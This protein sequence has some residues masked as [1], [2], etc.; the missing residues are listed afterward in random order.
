MIGYNQVARVN[1]IETAKIQADM[2]A[3]NLINGQQIIPAENLFKMKITCPLKKWRVCI[4]LGWMFPFRPGNISFKLMC[5]ITCAAVFFSCNSRQPAGL[6]IYNAKIYTVDSVFTIDEAMAV[7]NGKIVAVGKND[8]LLKRYKADSMINAKGMPVFPGF[9]DAH[10]HFL[11]YGRGLFDVDLFDC[12]DWDEAVER[13]KTFAR[14]HPS[15]SWI[16][17]RGWDQ[18]KW[19]GK[20]FPDNAKLNELFP[21]KPMLL[22]RVDGHAAVANAKALQLAGIIPGQ[23]IEGGEIE[24]KDGRLTGLLID[25][26]VELVKRVIPP[27]SKSD[28]EKWLMAAQRNCFAQGLTTITDCGLMYSDIAIIDSLQREGK[29]LMR[30]YVMLS[31]DTANFNRFLQRGPYK[32]E[33][34]YV[35]GV[36]AY[37]DG[38]LGSRGA[39]LLQPY[40]DKPGWH[41]FLLSS[42]RHFDSLAKMLLHTDFQLCTHAIGDSGNRIMLKIYNKYLQGQ[43]DKRWRIEHAQVIDTNDFALFG[44]TS[45]IPSVQPTHAT[46]DMYW[47]GDRLGPERLKGA[48]AYRQLL[49]QN[50]WIPLGTD[51]PVEDISPIKTFYAAVFRKDARGF[52]PNGFQMENALTREQALR[53]M[54][55]W[56]ARADFL[57]KEVGSIEV[58]KNADFVILDKDLMVV[59]ENQVLTTKVMATYINGVKLY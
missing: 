27:A 19:P 26:A 35:K 37:A 40:S 20:A 22:Q 31:D 54:T 24:T 4:N 14:E 53:G 23:K 52:P 10:A 41:G 36:K 45:V 55:I 58:G 25:N 12:K 38:A 43:N 18:N 30:L 8:E 56:A 51:F 3:A 13:V 5:F 1:R 44:K 50:G 48:Y 29:L 49:G 42:E 15:E 11:G 32:T 2:H 46:S 7:K 21:D 16:R 59:D 9:I 33:R 28:Y 17:G 39:C 47:A 6:L 34:L 57:E